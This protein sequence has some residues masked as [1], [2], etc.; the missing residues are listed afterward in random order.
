MEYDLDTVMTD[1]KGQ[2]VT[3]SSGDG[4]A[5][6]LK[7]GDVVLNAMLALDENDTA[8]TKVKKFRIAVKTQAGGKC[9]LSPEEVVL[10]KQCVG[11]FYNPLAVGRVYE[12]LG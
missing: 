12:L 4:P 11:K 2:P 7:L 6:I 10:I 8:E 3:Q 1:L 5:T 9:E